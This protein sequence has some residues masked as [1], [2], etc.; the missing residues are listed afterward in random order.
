MSAA[1][2]SGVAPGEMTAEQVYD[3]CRQVGWCLQATDGSAFC[4]CCGKWSTS[5]HTGVGRHKQNFDWFSTEPMKECFECTSKLS[6][7]QNLDPDNFAGDDNDVLVFLQGLSKPLAKSTRPCLARIAAP[8]GGSPAA[9][10]VAPANP[11][12]HDESAFNALAKEK[13]TLE[14]QV[15]DLTRQVGE[16]TALVADLTKRLDLS[17]SASVSASVSAHASAIVSTEFPP[18]ASSKGNGKGNGAGKRNIGK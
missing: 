18:L 11:R 1:A 3:W 6:A 17:A 7:V 5:S 15:H 13:A 14:R 12:T 10:P 4:L 9:S 2:G 16:L 8:S